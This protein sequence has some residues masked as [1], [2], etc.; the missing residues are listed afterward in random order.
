MRLNKNN[1]KKDNLLHPVVL[2]E[3]QQELSQ[4]DAHQ[5]KKRIKPLIELRE[6]ANKRRKTKAAESKIGKAKVGKTKRKTRAKKCQYCNDEGHT[7][8]ECKYMLAVLQMKADREAG[9]HLGL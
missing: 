9:V 7:I 6:E 1:K 5:R 4:K 8:K 2:W 3:S